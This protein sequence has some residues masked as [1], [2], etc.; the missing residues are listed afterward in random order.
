MVQQAFCQFDAAL[1]SPGKCFHSLFGAIGQ[2]HPF[3]N[4][5][6]ARLESGPTQTVEMSLMPEVLVCG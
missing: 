6:H 2:T 3:E 1:H 4:L 5:S